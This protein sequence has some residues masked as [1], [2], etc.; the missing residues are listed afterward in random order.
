LSAPLSP[1]EKKDEMARPLLR[2][3]QRAP[4]VSATE[5]TNKPSTVVP[6]PDPSSPALPSDRDEQVDM[7]GGVPS[8]VVQQG[9][10]DLKRGIQDTSRAPEANQ[11]YRQLK[12]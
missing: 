10:K 9:A 2:L 1:F 4:R 8:V 11:A 6:L 5:P 7:T 3:P 12:K